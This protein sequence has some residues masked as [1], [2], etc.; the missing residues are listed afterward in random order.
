[1]VVENIWVVQVSRHDSL[2]T[3]SVDLVVRAIDG[4]STALTQL[5]AVPVNEWSSGVQRSSNAD[6]V[7]IVSTL[8]H[9][10]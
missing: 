4:G 5:L 10:G 6:G 7:P 8:V 2:A 1:M 3:R 9:Y